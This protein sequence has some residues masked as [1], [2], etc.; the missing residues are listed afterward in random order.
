MLPI[1]GHRALIE[2]RTAVMQR[3]ALTVVA[4]L[5][6]DASGSV[7]A[8]GQPVLQRGDVSLDGDTWTLGPGA[9]VILDAG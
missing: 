4:N 7:I 8:A 3:G 9:T 5:G 1:A 2:C 6:A